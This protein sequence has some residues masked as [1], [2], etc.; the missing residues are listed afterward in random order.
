[1]VL[2]SAALNLERDKA[3]RENWLILPDAAKPVDRPPKGWKVE[4]LPSGLRLW[5]ASLSFTDAAN[6]TTLDVRRLNLDTSQSRPFDFSLSCQVAL[7]PYGLTGELSAQGEASYGDTGGHILVHRSQATGW[8]ELP[9]GPQAPGGRLAVSGKVMAHGQQGAVEISNMVVEG[10]GARLT[11]QLN[12]A[13][14]YGEK[15]YVYLNV[16]GKGTRAGL[17][18]RKL[19]LDLTGPGPVPAGTQLLRPAP[20]EN[21]IEGELTLSST[22]SGWLASKIALRDGPGRLGGTVRNIG[23]DI[24]FDVNASHWELGSW[25]PA[26]TLLA[27][28]PGQE[29]K[30]MN[31]RFTGTSLRAGSMEITELELSARSGHGEVRIYPATARI[32]QGVVSADIRL[33]PGAVSSAF[34]VSAALHGLAAQPP[35]AQPAL[36]LAELSV[37]GE[38]G[39]PGIS[40]KTHLAITEIPKDFKSDWA[41]PSVRKAWTLL[42]G[43]SAQAAFAVPESGP[44]EL[45]GLDVRTSVSRLTGKLTGTRQSTVLDI[46]ADKLDLDR[47]RQL[48]AI[49]GGDAGGFTPF[50]LEGRISAKRLVTPGLDV[51]DLVLAGQVSP[52]ALRLSTVSGLALGGRFSGGIEMES[53]RGASSLSLNLAATGVQGAALTALS[54]QMPK[55]SGPLDVRLSAESQ[56]VSP[57]PPWQGLRGQADLQMG[58]GSVTFSPGEAGAQPW[59]VS[60]AT[61][62]LKFTAKPALPQGG[63]RPREAVL[64]DL[65]GTVR[66][67]SPGLVRSSQ[68]ELKGQAGLDA[69]GRPLWFRQPKAEGSHLLALGFLGPGKTARASWTGKIDADFDTG[70]FSLGGLDLNLAGVPGRATLTGTPVQAGLALAGSVDIPE[71]NPRDVAPRLGLSLPAGSDPHVWRRAR[72]ASEI[73]GNLK[74]VRLER[75]QAM[76]DEAIITGQATV[77]G[78][79][80]RLDLS[81]SSLDLDRLAPVPQIADPA[82]RPEE[83]LP[84]SELRELSLDAKIRFGWL[85]KDRLVW[86]NALTEFSAQGGRFQLRQS[87][88]SFYGGPYVIEIRGDARGSELKAQMDLKLTN[89]STPALLKDLAGAQTLTKGQCDFFV[90]VETHGA[91]DRALRR[92]ATGTAGFEVRNGVLSI[93]E[94]QGKRD[95]PVQ[96]FNGDR[97]APPPASASAPGEGVPFTR[98]GASFSVREGLAITR[99]LALTG[100]ALTAKGDGWVSLDDERIDLN[101]MASVPDVGEVPVRISGPLYDPKL[102]IDKSKILGDTIMNIFKGVIG[103]PGSVINQLRRVF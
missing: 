34:S 70:A 11:G 56:P 55:I 48:S 35:A 98:L 49:F 27:A 23:G 100:T 95:A 85:M 78:A 36:P 68:M 3:G 62:A 64:A 45:S 28:G 92:R 80:N 72:F 8:L 58:A 25:F 26:G 53:A 47:L 71:F 2:S 5:N 82:K 18:A 73:G 51:D 7:N 57:A 14:L 84:L 38:M 97:D 86:E 96:S 87:A 4:S 41:S 15:P 99:D 89:F 1:V 103:I 17:W 63:E 91:T 101:L 32:D 20:P 40:G 66:V 42:G 46:Q 65:S 67:D 6:G 83:P 94:A 90:N 60:R 93:R 69:S 13:G 19:G 50:P 37:S 33:K 29:L 21:D 52:E 88:P 30:S 39:P 76:L 79:R 9:P 16:A 61:A 43:S 10:L 74:E 31:G 77:S 102:E 44:W 59:P 54:P 81:V 12:A 24:V 22:P 75:V